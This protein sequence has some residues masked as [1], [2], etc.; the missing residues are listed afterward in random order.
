MWHQ[1]LSTLFALG[2]VA[3]STTAGCATSVEDPVLDEQEMAADETSESS[4]ALTAGGGGWRGGGY[5]GFGKYGHGPG[6]GLALG[7]RFR[8]GF[9]DYAGWGYGGY[10]GGYGYDHGYGY[11]DYGYGGYGQDVNVIIENNVG[12]YVGGGYIDDD[13]L[14]D[15]W[16]G[17]YIGDIVDD[18]GG[19]YIDEFYGDD[20]N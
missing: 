18:C 15:D 16:G 5:R 9:G 3:I 14:G 17:G 12:G 1:K 10:L 6:R 20:W 8:H 2:L 11:G 7:R 13:F 4:E 19:G